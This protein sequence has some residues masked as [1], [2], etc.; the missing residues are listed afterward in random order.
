MTSQ[1]LPLIFKIESFLNG[2]GEYVNLPEAIEELRYEMIQKAI[3]KSEG[4]NAKAARMLGM[5]RTAFLH[6]TLGKYK[7]EATNEQ[8]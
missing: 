3:M 2:S 8:A 5:K 7:K 4:N 1:Y 6:Y